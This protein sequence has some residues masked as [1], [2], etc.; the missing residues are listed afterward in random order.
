MAGQAPGQA[1]P[2]GPRTRAVATRYDKWLGDRYF[3]VE[4]GR[5]GGTVLLGLPVGL[6]LAALTVEPI[7]AATGSWRIPLFVAAVP[8]LLLAPLVLRLGEPRSGSSDGYR[9]PHQMPMRRSLLAVLSV[10]ALRWV[11]V[12][13]IPCGIACTGVAGFLAPLLHR[14]FGLGSVAY[15]LVLGACGVVGLVLGGWLADRA[16][17]QSVRTRMLTGVCGAGLATVTTALSFTGSAVTFRVLFGL[18]VALVHGVLVTIGATIGD[19]AGPALRGTAVALSVALLSIPVGPL[20]VG[21]VSDAL[22]AT[23][24]DGKSLHDAL[25]WVVPPMLLMTGLCL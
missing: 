8:G 10:P 25:S 3:A 9:A 1:R 4:R 22:A 23:T 14:Q 7:A 20:V 18:S 6:T 12:G 17:R 16:R 21:A 19:L 2:T 13:C 5:A 24:A 15:A 11:L